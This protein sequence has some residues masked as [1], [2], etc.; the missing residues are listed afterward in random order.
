MNHF[1]GPRHVRHGAARGACSRRLGYQLL[2]ASDMR[3]ILLAAAAAF[4]LG[5]AGAHATTIADPTGD[6]LP[7]FVGPNDA[8]LD[9]TGFTVNFDDPTD[10]FML[11]ATLAGAVNP[12]RAGLYVVGV[13]T[14]TGLAHPFGGIGAPNVIFNQALVIQK[15]GAG[16]V[17]GHTFTAT[18]AGNSISALIPLSFL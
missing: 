1:A 6:F 16:V 9:V 3:K 17:S 14:G 12:S 13:N 2:G 10:T 5:A 7:T 18:I 15:T 11:N 4:A 8:D